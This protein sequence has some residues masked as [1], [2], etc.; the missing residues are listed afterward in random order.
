MRRKNNNGPF[1]IFAETELIVEFF[2]CDPANIVWHGNYYNYFETARR[3]LL[4]KIHYNYYDMKKS[5]YGFPVVNVSIK[6]INAIQYNDKI[7]IKAILEEYENCLKIK[8]EIRNVETGL[9]TTEGVTTQMAYDYKTNESCFACP[10]IFI[11]KVEALIK[12][13]IR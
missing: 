9:I 4:E 8:F 6:Y 12:G 5:G 11:D 7:S 13:N 1:N 10:Q 3:L 2:H